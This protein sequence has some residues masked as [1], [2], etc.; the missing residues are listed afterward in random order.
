MRNNLCNQT[1]GGC[2]LENLLGRGGMG[3]V[4]R[5]RH[6]NLD[7]PVA[8][9]ILD[10]QLA[11]S[12]EIVERFILEARATARLDSP[13]IVRVFQVGE[14]K[15]F[16]FIQMELVEG[17]SLADKTKRESILDV[18]TALSFL[19]QISMG[20]MAA[21][22]ANIIHRDIKPANI[23]LSNKG[24][25]KIT[26][27]GL[28]KCMELSSAITHSG[29]ILG[30]PY[31]L[32][33]EQCEGKPSDARSDIYALGVTFYFMLTGKCP[34]Q[35]ENFVAVALAKLH[36]EPP[37][38]RQTRPEIR[39]EIETLNL[40]M[41]A[42]APAARYQNMAEIVHDIQALLPGYAMQLP[43]LNPQVTPVPFVYTIAPLAKNVGQAVGKAGKKQEPFIVPTAT[44][45]NA[46]ELTPHPV[47]EKKA[48]SVPP[49][50][51]SK[52]EDSS[53]GK[54]PTPASAENTAEVTEE[55]EEEWETL[56]STSPS[57]APSSS[58][59]DRARKEYIVFD[60]QV[61]RKL[62]T[63]QARP[64]AT[65]PD[66]A[67]ETTMNLASDAAPD[68]DNKDALWG[69]VKG[70]LQRP[71]A[72]VNKV[73]TALQE[74]VGESKEAMYALLCKP[75]LNHAD[76]LRREGKLAEAVTYLR[77]SV[78]ASMRC[79]AIDQKIAE[80]TNQS[81]NMQSKLVRLLHRWM[82]KNT[83]E[84][85]LQ[86]VATLGESVV[87]QL[88][89]ALHYESWGVRAAAAEVLGKMGE[90]A[91][92]AIPDLIALLQD[93]NLS[94]SAAAAEALGAMGH[95]AEE[96]IPL[97]TQNLKN[98]NWRLRSAAAKSLAQIGGS[99]T[100]VLARTLKDK[101]P[102]VREA[103]AYALGEM[104]SEA[105]PAVPALILAMRDKVWEVR[106]AAVEALG[107]LGQHAQASI[108][109]L[110]EAL[111][112]ND[113]RMKNAAW[114]ALKKIKA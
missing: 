110:T 44:D 60:G 46:V 1:I 89:A 25:V 70:Y 14:E 95:K 61:T 36:S 80:L 51:L 87:T 27:F 5:A 43:S 98:W 72:F 37:S 4:Y 12:A 92:P 106:K 20:L 63:E 29:Q 94:V 2:R 39:R 113:N 50:Q 69:K 88:V 55:N 68:S 56:I 64:S 86:E 83:R 24:I 93:K 21:H 15:G 104:G 23:L 97:L 34:F 79:Q 109:A 82:D 114:L 16:Y 59:T 100:A 108:P 75:Y 90:L 35:G 3:D 31:Y 66:L 38:P 54:A 49:L 6:L 103:S 85:A 30:T 42:R 62:D 22:S 32:A 78:P 48:E 53:P 18:G 17:E 19:Y 73:K 99:A 47:T 52:K 112:D 77:D 74:E 8:V 101:I 33:P 57:P 102:L 96:A 7:I 45:L 58:H 28:A 91:Y 65:E 9:K 107:K 67:K 11:S 81:Q 76:S 84:V 111:Q 26:D 71:N 10:S 40:K 41:I 13:Y 105:A